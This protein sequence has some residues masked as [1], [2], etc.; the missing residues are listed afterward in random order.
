MSW[1]ELITGG[2]ERLP[3]TERVRVRLAPDLDGEAHRFA[4]PVRA[5]PGQIELPLHGR[6]VAP[7]EPPPWLEM[8]APAEE[9]AARPVSPSHLGEDM[10]P[11]VASPLDSAVSGRYQRGRV[12]HRLLQTLPGRPPETAKRD[13]ARFLAQPGIG[14]DAAQ[15][16]EIAAEVRAVLEDAELAPLF[17]PGSRAE[18]PIA[19]VLNGLP[20]AGQ[21]DRLAVSESEVLVVDY[22]TNREPPASI[23][24]VPEAYLRQMAAYRGLLQAIYPGRGVRCALL[25]T[26]GPTLMPLPEK[27]LS[28]HAPARP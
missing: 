28:S 24:Q 7:V 5:R 6:P 26:E 22:K 18:V 20:I 17:G 2:L 14:L 25:W 19:G 16:A 27:T 23:D 12:I 15:Q 10:E 9:A 21:V 13:M 3:R 1:H 4:N 8:P 11:P